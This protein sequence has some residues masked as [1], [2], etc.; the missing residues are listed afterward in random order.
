MKEKV[1]FFNIKDIMNRIVLIYVFVLLCHTKFNWFLYLNIFF[2]FRIYVFFKCIF[3][4]YFIFY[5]NIFY[6]FCRNFLGLH[7][8][9]G[10]FVKS[11]QSFLCFWFCYGWSF[12]C[13]QIQDGSILVGIAFSS[14]PQFFF[15]IF[16]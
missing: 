2:V 16:V 11:I 10:Y 3:I 15:L 14:I 13:H 6:K 8:N 9:F 5:F 12:I 4:F 1:F 7:Q